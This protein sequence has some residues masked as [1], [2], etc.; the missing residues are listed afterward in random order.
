MANTGGRKRADHAPITGGRK[1]ADHGGTVLH[2]RT[3]AEDDAHS[4]AASDGDAAH[5]DADSDAN[6]DMAE[7][8]A[9]TDSKPTGD[10]GV[11]DSQFLMPPPLCVKMAQHVRL[12]CV[13]VSDPST[14]RAGAQNTSR[15]L[16]IEVYTILMRC[17]SR[18]P[19]P[20]K[21]TASHRPLPLRLPTKATRR[22]PPYH[23][24]LRRAP[25]VLYGV[26]H[27]DPPPWHCF[28][29]VLWPA[30]PQRCDT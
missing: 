26:K 20:T 12:R 3:T 1:R 23:L 11:I 28:R 25:Y 19:L 13:L 4:D 27:I 24:A 21:P 9:E 18:H 30:F 29:A 16:N 22:V 6:V 5:A 17:V 7:Q 2:R 15:F 10:D 8:D 14:A